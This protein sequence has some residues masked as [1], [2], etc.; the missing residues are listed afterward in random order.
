[1]IMFIVKQFLYW[2]SAALSE[3]ITLSKFIDYTWIVVML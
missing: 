1:M 2:L 3:L